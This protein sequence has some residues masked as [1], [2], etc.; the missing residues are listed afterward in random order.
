VLTFKSSD[1]IKAEVLGHEGSHTADRQDY[2]AA[3]MTANYANPSMTPEAG[4]DLPENLTK[5]KTENRA[6][7]VSSYVQ[8]YQNTPGKFWNKGWRE[9][10]RQKAIN[11]HLILTICI[12]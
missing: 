5:Y 7:H 3:L 6:Y 10:D 9:A 2:V 8:E 12:K 1:E 4:R 11:N